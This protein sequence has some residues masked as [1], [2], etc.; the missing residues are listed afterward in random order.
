MPSKRQREQHQTRDERNVCMPSAEMMTATTMPSS[1]VRE[2]RSVR[3]KKD[4]AKHREEI[5]RLFIQDGWTLKAIIDHMRL[6][7]NFRAA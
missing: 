4:W 2:T 7:R 3:E 1:A 6:H 5:E